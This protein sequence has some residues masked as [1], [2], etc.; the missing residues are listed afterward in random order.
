MNYQFKA[1]RNFGAV[2]LVH[3]RDDEVRAAEYDRMHQLVSQPEFAGIIRRNDPIAPV[4][5]RTSETDFP[6]LPSPSKTK[7]RK[8]VFLKSSAVKK[9]S[10]RANKNCGTQMS[11]DGEETVDPLSLPRFSE[12]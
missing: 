10:G 7:N 3:G 11:Y 5:K 4:R 12:R 2:N 6:F 8:T 1:M 9:E